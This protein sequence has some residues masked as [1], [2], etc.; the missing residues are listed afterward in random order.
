MSLVAQNFRLQPSIYFQP[1][2]NFNVQHSWNIHDMMELS[3]SALHSKKKKQHQ[4]K[5]EKPVGLY[6]KHLFCSLCGFTLFPQ[7]GDDNYALGSR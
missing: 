7:P 1:T 3:I 4:L 6:R 5:K 2:F